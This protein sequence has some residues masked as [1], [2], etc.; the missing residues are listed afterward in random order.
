MKKYN[1][2][3]KLNESIWVYEGI[4]V[5]DLLKELINANGE[6]ISY[7]EG[8]NVKGDTIYIFPE[9]NN[10][11]VY[12]K[13]LDVYDSCLSNYVIENN[14]N[15]TLENLDL[16]LVEPK[17]EGKYMSYDTIAN[18]LFRKYKPGTTMAYHEDS[19][20]RAYGGGFTVILYLNDNYVGGELFF[21]DHNIKFKPSKGSVLVFPGNEMHEILLLEEGERYMISGYFFKDKRP[22]ALSVAQNGYGSDGSKFWL[23]ANYLPGNLGNI[24]HEIEEK[25]Y[26]KPVDVV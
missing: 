1:T 7:T 13:V 6:W 8:H 14:L 24:K 3:N 11:D 18:I 10:L 12:N 17:I 23:N 4:D 22:S 9:E 15:M 2:I 26:K 20:H 16:A 25:T 19:V 5:D 21:K